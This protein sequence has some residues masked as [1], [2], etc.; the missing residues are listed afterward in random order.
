MIH[1]I[2]TTPNIPINGNDSFPVVD[3]AKSA[4]ELDSL[5][6]S[7]FIQILQ[8]KLSPDEVSF[9]AHALVRLE[10]RNIIV[11][12]QIR[13]Q[14]GNAIEKIAQK[15]GRESLIM[16]DDIAYLVSIPNKTVITAL[17]ATDSNVFTN[18]D[19]ALLLS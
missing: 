5:R 19:S 15:G 10:Q 1:R 3:R 14:L 18:I 11:D 13:A 4:Q 17:E 6:Q 9:S 8:D 12:E 16:L 7:S 2:V